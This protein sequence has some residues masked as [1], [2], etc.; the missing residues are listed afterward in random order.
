MHIDVIERMERFLD[1]PWY[2][3]KN[4]LLPQ[5][6]LNYLKLKYSQYNELD[7]CD[8]WREMH[9]LIQECEQALATESINASGTSM[10]LLGI[11][12]QKL[13]SV[14]HREVFSLLRAKYKREA[15]LIK[16]RNAQQY[17]TD[18]AK[19]VA[20]EIWDADI[21]NVLS[22][23][24]VCHELYACLHTALQK[25][26]KNE[27]N[28]E[29]EEFHTLLYKVFPKDALGFKPHIRSVAPD[30]STRPGRRKKKE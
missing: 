15:P 29:Q 28:K 4:E 6:I 9:E 14:D 11:L 8:D 2:K 23:S 18:I 10:F 5:E 12:T 22:I 25:T 13:G 20:T 21:D 24:D 16:K 27:L 7:S 3:S 19:D 17:L 30:Y 26:G 1:A